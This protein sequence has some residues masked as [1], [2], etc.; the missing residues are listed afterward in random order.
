MNGNIEIP[1]TT[2]EARSK[3]ERLEGALRAYG[4][5]VVAYSGGVDS[6]FLAVAATRVLGDK[7]LAV[8]AGSASLSPE[9][10][11]EACEIAKRFG[12]RHRVVKTCELED[13]E[14]ASNPLNRCYFCKKELM[15]RLSAV[16]GEVGAERIA[17]GAIVDDL[18]DDRPG[19]TAAAERGA[20][21]PLRD[22]G[23][24][25]IEVRML[26]RDLG[27]PTATKPGGACL[28]SRVPFMEEVTAGK[29]E[30]VARAEALLHDFG[31]PACRVRH[32]GVTARIEVP[33]AQL[34]DLVARHEE[35][36]ARLKAL[37]FV[38]VTLDLQGLRSGSM[39]E[40]VR[41]G[42]P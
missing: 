28:A 12:L 37:G 15:T 22:A 8:T 24:T 27:L 32:H 11:T 34:G 35:V 6:T 4:S 17:V 29:L 20:V 19:E 25:K 33:V 30:Q 38:Y 36:V 42:D 5:V 31:F 21:F 23:L 7:A 18:S 41:A 3:L 10:L 14:Y 1:G 40:A 39:H 26:S 13:A 16:S 9:E 2:D